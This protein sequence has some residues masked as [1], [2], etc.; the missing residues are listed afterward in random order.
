MDKLNMMSWI[1]WFYAVVSSIILAIVGFPLPITIL[2]Y[3]PWLVAIAL[4]IQK[5]AYE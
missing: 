4:I 1:A 3:V 2:G 5:N